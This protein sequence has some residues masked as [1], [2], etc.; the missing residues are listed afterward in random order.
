MQFERLLNLIKH[1]PDAGPAGVTC[2]LLGL[3]VTQ[4]VNVE[5]GTQLLQSLGKGQRI[6]PGI[7][8]DITGCQMCR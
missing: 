2:K 7:L 1:A 4:E 5:L 8:I 6:F 3:P